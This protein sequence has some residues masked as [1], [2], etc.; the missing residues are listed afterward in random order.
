[1]WIQATSKDQLV[2][3]TR[4]RFYWYVGNKLSDNFAYEATFVD[5]D[6]TSRIDVLG[7]Y[8][9]YV[10]DVDVHD[11]KDRPEQYK[12][13]VE[14]TSPSQYIKYVFGVVMREWDS[15]RLCGGGVAHFVENVLSEAIMDNA[16]VE[17][18]K[19]AIV[20]YVDDRYPGEFADLLEEIGIESKPVKLTITIE[21]G[22]NI[23]FSKDEF[24]Q[25][26]RDHG[27]ERLIDVEVKDV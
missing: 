17:D 1:M 20:E 13:W 6:G 4:F 5:D 2:K 26:M 19:L 25:W 8:Q 21:S 14:A 10:G 27:N 7:E 12:I 18:I 15:D 3:G 16:S 23:T 9:T 11:L 22:R 24:I